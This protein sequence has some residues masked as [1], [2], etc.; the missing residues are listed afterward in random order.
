VAFITPYLEELVQNL[1]HYVVVNSEEQPW[2]EVGNDSR[3]EY[4]Q[5]PDLCIGHEAIVTYRTPCQHNDPKV[6][7]MRRPTFKFGKLTHWKLRSCIGDDRRGKAN[8]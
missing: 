1:E 2:L 4:R 5:K 6:T 7:S 8:N 3:P